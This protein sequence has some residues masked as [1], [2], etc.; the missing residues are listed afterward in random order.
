MSH[1]IEMNSIRTEDALVTIVVIL[2]ALLTA[3]LLKRGLVFLLWQLYD[4]FIRK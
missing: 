3:P 2:V 1:K 4:F